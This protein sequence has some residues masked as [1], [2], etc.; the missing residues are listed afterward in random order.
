EIEMER[1]QKSEIGPDHR[2]RM[3]GSFHS[4]RKRS[5]ATADTL[6]TALIRLGVLLFLAVVIMAF[7]EWGK[8]ALYSFFL[9]LP[10]Y[11]YLK[12]RRK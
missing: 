2:K 7:L 10:V 12:F 1:G 11:I 9:F 5:K 8:V 6:N 4:A 3:L